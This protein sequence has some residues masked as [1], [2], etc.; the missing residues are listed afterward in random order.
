MEKLTAGMEFDNRYLLI[1]PIGEGSFGEVWLAE[2]H[3]VNVQVAIKIYI[4][5]DQKGLEVFKKEFKVSYSLN[6]A[7]LLHA[8]YCSICEGHPYIVMPYCKN[9]S[10]TSKIGKIDKEQDVWKLINDISSGIA[11]LHKHNIVHQDIKPQNILIDDDGN[12]L[13]SD[14]GESLKIKTTLRQNTLRKEDEKGYGGSIPY[15]APERFSQDKLPVMLSDMWSLGAT[16]YEVVE[17]ELPFSGLGGN[18]QKHGAELPHLSAKWSSELNEVVQKCLA[19]ATWD[20]IKAADLSKLS[21]QYVNNPPHAEQTNGSDEPEKG[22]QGSEGSAPDNKENDAANKRLNN[23]TI[24]LVAACV[25]TLLIFGCGL[26]YLYNYKGEEPPVV[27]EMSYEGESLDG[28]KSGWGILT[29]SLGDIYEGN[30]KYDKC[31]GWGIKQYANNGIYK[32]QWKDDMRSGYGYYISPDGAVKCGI[33]ENDTIDSGQIAGD[34]SR[35]VYGID[36][37]KYQ[38]AVDFGQIAIPVNENIQYDPEGKYLQPVFFTM[39]KATE[40]SDI[41]DPFF[42]SSFNTARRYHMPRGA[43]HL[44]TSKS[45]IENQIRLYKEQVT[46]EEGDFPPILDLERESLRHWKRN[47][48]IDNIRTWVREMEA[49]YKVKPI[50]YSNE[51]IYNLY[52]ANQGFHQYHFWIANLNRAPLAGWTFWQLSHTARIKGTQEKVRVDLDKFNGSYQEF[53]NFLEKYGVK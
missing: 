51:E 10:L 53:C 16:V 49:Y 36:L 46:L 41:V 47:E 33:W 39:I 18:M 44:L 19:P 42:E 12:Y 37:S 38:L 28:E 3:S 1:E 6:H 15:M 2:D 25:V 32:G 23:R 11:Y 27:E 4:H 43:Y 20:R 14:Y 29:S 9:G 22:K 7:N 40:G 45:P 30:F 34:Q 50:I 8:N 31:N 26:Y 24:L 52:L 21:L 48:I 17:G 35:V 5:I 13:I